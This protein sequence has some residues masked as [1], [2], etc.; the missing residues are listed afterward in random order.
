MAGGHAPAPEWTGI[1]K[2]VRGYFPQDYQLA[3]AVLGGYFTLITISMIPGKKKPVK[4]EAKPAAP[5]ATTGSS[6]ILSVDM[7]E[8][9]EGEVFEKIMSDDETFNKF[10]GG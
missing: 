2:V 5:A 8:I 6:E 3:M 1:D 4:E 10:L 7:A 9:F